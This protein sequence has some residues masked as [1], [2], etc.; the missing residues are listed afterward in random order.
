MISRQFSYVVLTA[1]YAINHLIGKSYV[2]DSIL[3]GTGLGFFLPS[4]RQSK[5]LQPGLRWK[6]SDVV[7]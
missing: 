6:V 3:S 4:T 5:G 1:V 2:K 7:R